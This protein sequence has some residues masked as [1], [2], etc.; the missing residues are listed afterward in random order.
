MTRMQD[1]RIIAPKYSLPEVLEQPDE[2]LYL[3]S[4]HVFLDQVNDLVTKGDDR[5]AS[6]KNGRH[7]NYK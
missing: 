6:F 1:L 5:Y 3:Q 2:P 4:S 7:S